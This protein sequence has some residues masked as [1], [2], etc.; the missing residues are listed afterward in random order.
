MTQPTTEIDPKERIL[1]VDDEEDICAVLTH[2]LTAKGYAVETASSCQSALNLF[3]SK[4]FTLVLQDIKM[5]GMGGIE[6]IRRYKKKEPSVMIVVITAFSNFPDEV[7]AMRLGVYD[8]LRKPFDNENVITTVRRALKA[9]EL[10][11]AFKE[12]KNNKPAFKPFIGDNEKIQAIYDIIHRVTGTDSTVLIQGENGTGKELV[13][14]TLHYSSARAYGPF[15]PVNCGSFPEHLLESE[16]FGHVKGAFTNAFYD[17]K[18]LMEAADNG[19]FFLDEVG[20]FSPALQVKLLRVIEEREIKP[21]GST[22]TKKI[23]VRFIAATNSDLQEKVKAGEFRE[24]LF[25]RLNVITINLPPLRERRDDIPL[26]AGHFLAKYNHTLKKSVT[27]FT[28]EALELLRSYD[29]PGNVRELENVIQ[30]AV[31]LTKNTFIEPGNLSLK[32]LGLTAIKAQDN[33]FPDEGINLEEKAKDMEVDYILKALDKTNSNITQAANLL[34][35]PVRALRYKIKKY[36]I[37]GK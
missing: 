27:R 34:K 31:I 32:S 15:I 26:L 21:I 37:G 29:W 10:L 7:E 9:Q 16:L 25:Y 8:Y 35:I 12:H 14:R 23:D 3:E 2:A 1:V 30:R 28:P 24:D 6:L 19:T 36:E 22:E 17:K 13:A 20:E 5:P 18:G 33:F 4:S 11:S